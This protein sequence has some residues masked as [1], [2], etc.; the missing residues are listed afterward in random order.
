MSFGCIPVIIADG[1]ILPTDRT[2]DWDAISFHV[3]EKY[4][5]QIPSMLADILPIQ[6][7]AMQR[8]VVRA[9]VSYLSRFDSIVD[10]ISRECGQICA[11]SAQQG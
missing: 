10:C 3:P 7:A 8:A 6:A 2:I 11:P 1:L 4:I 9:H 5:G